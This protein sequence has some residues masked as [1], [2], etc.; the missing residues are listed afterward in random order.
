ML[1]LIRNLLTRPWF[2]TIYFSLFATHALIVDLDAQTPSKIDINQQRIAFQNQELITAKSAGWVFNITDTPKLVWRDAETIKDLGVNIPIQIQWFDQDLEP[3]PAPN[4]QGRW[5]AYIEGKAP[6][7][8]PFRRAF[9]FFA[10]P[11][12]LDGKLAPDLKPKFPNF[13]TPTTSPIWGEHREEIEKMIGDFVIR[14]FLENQAGAVL[15]SNIYESPVRNRSALFIESAQVANADLHAALQQK[16]HPRSIGSNQLKSPRNLDSSAPLLRVGQPQE[17]GLTPQSKQQIDDYC[18]RWQAAT[19][20][21][22]VTLVAKNGVII[23]HEAFG[24]DKSGEPIDRDYRC[25]I[26]SL[27]KTLTAI[28]FSQFLDQNLIE[29]DQTLDE[30]FEEFPKHHPGVPTFRQCL[31]HTSGLSG[32]TD[33]GGMF[34]PHLEN[35]VLNAIDV[36]RPGIA[37]AYSGLGYEIVAKAMERTVGKSAVRIYHD[38]LFEPL[39]FG[40][41]RLGNAGSDGHLT[42]LELG[43]LGQWLANRGRYGS[44]EFISPTTFEQLLPQPLDVPNAEPYGAGLHWF[45]HVKPGT[46]EK[47]TDP[48][49]WLFSAT[50]VGH[51]SMAG[52]ILVVDLEQQ[53]VI[54][55]ARREFHDNDNSWWQGFFPVVAQAI[56]PPAP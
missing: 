43:I 38:H 16:L 12:N 51:G 18:R 45:R 37:S 22:F 54:V 40:D 9:T 26:A 1:T 31:N 5:L 25:W 23:T 34:Q 4:H 32:I 21:P 10:I 19:G 41:V 17:I 35:I 46:P 28:M 11:T 2:Q 13:N 48:H 52:C 7:Q 14:G 27:T 36:N 44:L 3:S 6:N 55:Q 30:V 24:V 20:E 56:D 53:L 42:A 29:L 50:T 49:D 8:F 15:L 39:G 33:H 47:S